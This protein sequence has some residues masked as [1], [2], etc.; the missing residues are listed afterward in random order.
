MR[1]D[2]K[3]VFVMRVLVLGGAGL[4][5][6][7]VAR[8]LAKSGVEAITI[9]DYNLDGAENIAQEVKE[10]GDIQV[11]A[12][13]F[14][15]ND[16]D[17]M[18]EVM[19]ESEADVVVNMVG[20]Y[21]EYGVI[22]PKAAIEARLNYIDINDDTEPAVEVLDTLDEPAKEAGVSVLIG[23]GAT[24]GMSNMLAKLGST[25][26]DK[27][28][29]ITIHWLWPGVAGSGVGAFMHSAHMSEGEVTQFLDG[30]LTQVPAWSEPEHI[31]SSDG[32]SK[33][34]VVYLGHGE[35]STLPRYI[36]GVQN[37][38]LKGGLMPEEVHDY[39]PKF[40]AA[41]LADPEPIE[42]QGEIVSLPHVAMAVQDRLYGGDE[43]HHPEHGY[44]SITVEGEKDGEE[45]TIVY[46]MA[47]TGDHL[48]SWPT[49]I[50]TQM[51]G[52]GEIDHPGANTPEV[53]SA[54]EIQE[55][56]NSMEERGIELKV[57]ERQL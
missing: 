4:E 44:I 17:G 6:S 26:L 3:G 14:D 40:K 18:V 54:D 55:V 47:G 1:S 42:V 53:L 52:D 19:K 48:T 37:V 56:I 8:D 30:E 15:A 57:T 31:E 50:L 41:G 2:S 10:L 7:A 16:Y 46:E 5:G 34:K 36:D 27:T 9:A 23:V 33:G 22:I 20:P 45:T 43:Y 32:E 25:E 38:V 11:E 13:E 49:S 51:M 12:V 39:V 24:P 21:Y 28:E 35:P 29:N